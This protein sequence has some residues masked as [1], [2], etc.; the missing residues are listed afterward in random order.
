V[1]GHTGKFSAPG[2]LPA[3]FSV[4]IEPNGDLCIMGMWDPAIPIEIEDGP[5]LKGDALMI[6]SEKGTPLAAE[7]LGEVHLFG[8]G[9]PPLTIHNMVVAHEQ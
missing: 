1:K 8:G 3:G 9:I 4:E 6:L 2:I 7:G 5:V